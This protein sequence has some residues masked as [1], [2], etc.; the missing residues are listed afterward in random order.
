[1][2]WNGPAFGGQAP[3]GLLPRRRDPDRHDRLI[4]MVNVVFLLLLFFVI[5]GTFRAA[6]TFRVEPPQAAGGGTFDPA[7]LTLVVAS[8]GEMALGKATVDM[9]GAVAGIRDWLDAHPGGDI[10]IKADRRVRA[11]LVV[12][13]LA[14]LANAGVVN[15]RLIAVRP[16]ARQ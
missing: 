14:E 7:S 6:D 13:L 4:P 9:A 8:S 3:V 2:R 15:I 5:A 1:M 11:S 16:E 12:P 10:Q